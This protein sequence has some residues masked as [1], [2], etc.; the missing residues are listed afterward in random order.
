MATQIKEIKELFDALD[1]DGEG[2]ISVDELGELFSSMGKPMP[3][4]KLAQMI[5]EVDSDGGGSIE[6][7]EFL[8]LVGKQMA[9]EKVLTP[10]EQARQAFDMFDTDHGGTIDATELGAALRAM[11]QNVS[12][13]EVK[14]ML[15]EVD[16]DGTGE[17]EFE[18]FCDLM[19]IEPP[20]KVKIDEPLSLK[21]ASKAPAKKVEVTDYKAVLTE[22]EIKEMKEVFE[23]FDEDGGG[24]ISVEE[25]GKMM[26]G[27][28]K[29]MSEEELRKMI[30]SV[31]DPP[32][33]PAF[34]NPR[35]E[36]RML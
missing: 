24:N 2:S 3:K 1:A 8:M 32:S 29:P 35:C 16:D 33:R 4:E 19:G 18:E 20:K 14:K 11:G 5:A 12:E 28:G 34:G 7:E 17:I 15:A 13:E 6:F 26:E 23:I 9:E 22:D 31:G 36:G 21:G 30:S 10:L 25:L 27:L